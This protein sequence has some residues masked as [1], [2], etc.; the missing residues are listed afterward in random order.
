MPKATYDPQPKKRALR[1]FEA[2]LCFVNDELEECD[3]LDIK[4]NWQKKDSTTPKLLV[5]TNLRALEVL[6]KKDNHEGSLTKTQIR[7]VLYRMQDFLGILEDNRI[8]NQGAEEWRFTLTLWSSDKAKNLIQFEQTWES[9]RPNKSKQQEA[10]QQTASQTIK[11]TRPITGVTSLVPYL[12]PYFVERP[13]ASEK[14]KQCLFSEATSK[15][16]T[17][18]VSA[19]YGLGGIGKSTLAAALAYDPDVQ[20]H[21]PDGIL[22]ITLGQQPDL[23]SC[24]TLF[25]HFPG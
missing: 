16:G 5:K 6:T 1:L 25:C 19:I 9:K 18:V 15:T 2:L 21:F 20:A 8:Q 17:L 14:L 3:R 24:L 10:A 11:P 12:P 23:L 22:W 7:E 4:C 13:E